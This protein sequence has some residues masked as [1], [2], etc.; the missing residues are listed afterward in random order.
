M[1]NLIIA[2]II[3]Q[4]V[5]NVALAIVLRYL[6]KTRNIPITIH[7]LPII[8]MSSFIMVGLVWLS[9]THLVTYLIPGI[10]VGYL[11]WFIQSHPPTVSLINKILLALFG[12]I[13]WVQVSVMTMFLLIHHDRFENEEFR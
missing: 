6:S 1:H 2:F 10:F 3:V 12:T 11:V 13:F 7:N 9:V 5:L 8:I 4:M